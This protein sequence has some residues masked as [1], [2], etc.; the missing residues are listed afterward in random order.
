MGDQGPT[1][2][3]ESIK[4]YEESRKATTVVP[5]VQYVTEYMKKRQEREFDPVL[6]MARDPSAVYTLKALLNAHVG[7]RIFVAA[8]NS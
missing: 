8:Q 3:G 4:Q 1:S 7:R 6:Q 2:W 5:P